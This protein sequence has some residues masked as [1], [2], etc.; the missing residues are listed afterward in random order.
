MKRCSIQ[1]TGVL[2][3]G[4]ESDPQATCDTTC[5]GFGRFNTPVAAP[6]W[7]P[8]DGL[9][10]A[11]LISEIIEGKGAFGYVREVLLDKMLNRM[12]NTCRQQGATIRMLQRKIRDLGG[13]LDESPESMEVREAIAQNLARQAS[14]EYA[15][16]GQND[17]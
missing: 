2:R 7:C 8:W 1:I 12:A 4:M 6:N 11:E 5:P 3:G 16:W 10:L 9:S 14:V 15:D 13:I 17:S